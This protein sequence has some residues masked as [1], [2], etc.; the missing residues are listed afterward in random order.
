MAWQRG[1]WCIFVLVSDSVRVYFDTVFDYSMKCL[2]FF[3]TLVLGVLPGSVS[4]ESARVEA[5]PVAAVDAAAMAMTLVPFLSVDV[6]DRGVYGQVRQV[7]LCTT[8]NH[9]GQPMVFVVGMAQYRG[10]SVRPFVLQ[11]FPAYPDSCRMELADVDGDGEQEVLIASETGASSYWLR[12]YVLNSSSRHVSSAD[13]MLGELLC[14]PGAE[15][16]LESN[17]VLRVVARG[18]ENPRFRPGAGAELY[19]PN[20]TTRYRFEVKDGKKTA[21][22]IS[23]D[24]PPAE[25]DAVRDSAS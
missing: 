12:V 23:G 24:V 11:S 20:V 13:R 18:G 3:S 9:E 22:P 7:L 1:A 4:G 5:K 25:K 15:Y 19:L 2:F 21:V 10:G 8:D 16:S 17:G 6:P 14:I